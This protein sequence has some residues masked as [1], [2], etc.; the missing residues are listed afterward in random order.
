MPKTPGYETN[1]DEL[2]HLAAYCTNE[3]DGCDALVA[4][5][6]DGDWLHEVDFDLHGVFVAPIDTFGAWEP[7]PECPGASFAPALATCPSCGTVY[8]LAGS[9]EEALAATPGGDYT[10]HGGSK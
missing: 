9:L 3:A 10:V 2:P 7:V 6:E 8:R 5:L 1:T 4:W